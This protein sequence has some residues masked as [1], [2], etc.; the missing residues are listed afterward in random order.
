MMGLT[1][2]Y[3]LLKKNGYTPN[4]VDKQDLRGKTVAIDGDFVLYKALHGYTHGKVNPEEIASHVVKWL[5]TA[6]T[7]GINTLFVTTGGKAPIEKQTH[8]HP[9]RKRKRKAQVVNIKA[10]ESRLI[11]DGLDI[12]DELVLRD[13]ICRLKDQIR[14]VDASTS[15]AVVAILKAAGFRCLSAVS[16]ADFLLVTC[17]EEHVCDFVATEDSD[18]IVAGAENVLRGFVKLLTRNEL[19]YSFNRADIL[20]RLKITSVQLM[21]LGCLLSC[22][23]QPKI[24]NL[25]PVGALKA[26]Q[27]YGT[28]EQFIR[29]DAFNVV[30]SKT[31]QRKFTLPPDM[32]S[33]AY[34]KCCQQSVEIFSSR[35]DKKHE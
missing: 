4:T 18:I 22:D 5:T 16:E 29:S 26:I 20:V 7:A 11:E 19:A 13:K 33:D 10:L 17:A 32:C 30:S 21:E 1:G 2:F 25:G 9:I 23:Y 8:G 28:I 35:P 15:K 34:L 3:Q 27:T 31:K 14:R 24:G 12:A 6:E